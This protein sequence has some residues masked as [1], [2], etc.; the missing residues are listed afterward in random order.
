VSREWANGAAGQRPVAESAQA[1]RTNG[2]WKL[3]QA[4]CP[5]DRLNAYF[6][7]L[8]DFL[9]DAC[10]SAGL[11]WSPITPLSGQ[12]LKAGHFAQP[13]TIAMGQRVMDLS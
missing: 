10:G 13:V 11:T 9:P 4:D 3:A 7:A 2:F 5:R 8:D 1:R 6:F 12:I